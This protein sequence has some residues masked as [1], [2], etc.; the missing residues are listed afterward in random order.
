[1]S[2]CKVCMSAGSINRWGYCEVCGEELEQSSTGP[3]WG[4]HPVASSVTTLKVIE[5]GAAKA[6]AADLDHEE[7]DHA[8]A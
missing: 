7:M 4:F 8:T 2:D 5:G 6:V 1:M 3:E